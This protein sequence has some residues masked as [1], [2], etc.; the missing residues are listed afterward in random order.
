MDKEV[1][2]SSFSI[3]YCVKKEIT[4]TLGFMKKWWPVQS[5]V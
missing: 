1:N 3:Q 5:S 4:E 2:F